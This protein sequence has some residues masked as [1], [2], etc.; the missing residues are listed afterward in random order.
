M[1]TSTWKTGKP[2]I[3]A[4]G[5]VVVRPDEDGKGEVAVIHRPKYMDWSLPKGKLE[6]GEDW[7]EA[8]LREVEE[9]TGFP[10]RGPASSCL[11]LLPGPQRPAK[12]V[13]Y[14]LMEPL[15][16][17]F[18]PHDEVDELRWLTPEEAAEL[19]TYEHDQELVR[20]ALRRYRW[21]KLMR[22]LTPWSRQPMP[23]M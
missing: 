16:G 23:G 19:L 11:S 3:A 7:R 10:L 8:A 9:E 6:P 13:R 14:W 22:A 15:E 21:R 2:D 12:F 1:T 4:A 5:G 18:K 17:E 20:K